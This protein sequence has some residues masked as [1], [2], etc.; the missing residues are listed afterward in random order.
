[1]LNKGVY[2][3]EAINREPFD[4]QEVAS[5]GRRTFCCA[6]K[7]KGAGGKSKARPHCPLH[8]AIKHV[9]LAA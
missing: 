9:S 4:E 2:G 7:T 5:N 1:M 6:S 8:S 3:D